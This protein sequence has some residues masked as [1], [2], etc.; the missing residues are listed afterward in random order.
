M[1][2]KLVSI[3]KHVYPREVYEKV[4]R[5]HTAFNRSRHKMTVITPSLHCLFP[6]LIENYSNAS[7]PV[8]TAQMIIGKRS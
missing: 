3:W 5:F 7:Q 4:K 6:P 1:F 2:I 8:L